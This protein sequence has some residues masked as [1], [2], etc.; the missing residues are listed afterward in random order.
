MDTAESEPMQIEEQPVVKTPTP[1][2]KI[3]KKKVSAP[4]PAPAP[5]QEEIVP[6]E[7]AP[8]IDNKAATERKI[9]APAFIV[10][11]AQPLAS[12]KLSAQ[13]MKL[14]K[15]GLLLYRLLMGGL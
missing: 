14:V 12:D 3:V 5:E 11:I 6:E 13:L 7:D 2:R 10:P 1:K 9:E 15:A 4:A 8:A